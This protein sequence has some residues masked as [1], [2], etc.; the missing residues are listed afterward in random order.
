MK[1]ILLIGYY[2]YGNYGDDLLLNS[3]LKILNE[4]K[5]DGTIILPLEN[6]IEFKSNHYFNI[7]V[8]PRFN[9][10]EL[11]KSIKSSDLIIYGGGNLFQSET[12]YRSLFY[13]SYIANIA[14]KENKKILLLSQGFGSFKKN[15]G[16]KKLKKILNY[17][18]LYGILRDR[19]SYEFAKKYNNNINLGVDIGPYFF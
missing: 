11:K 9:F 16:L 14:A 19:T 3:F 6:E 2:G 8:V 12:S 1:K 15:R 18:N 5:F 13:Y 17:P 4:L 10:Y 7:Q